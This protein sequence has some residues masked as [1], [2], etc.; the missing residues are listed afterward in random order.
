[1]LASNGCSLKASDSFTN[2]VSN[3]EYAG[4]NAGDLKAPCASEMKKIRKVVQEQFSAKKAWK[5]LRVRS[6]AFAAAQQ[7]SEVEI[8]L[9]KAIQ[10]IALKEKQAMKLLEED[11]EYF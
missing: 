9:N 11:M 7:F 2:W 8:R 10:D 1:M 5:K 3:I 6:K 4:Q